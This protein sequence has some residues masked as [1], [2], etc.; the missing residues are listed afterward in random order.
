MK[1]AYD[2]ENIWAFYLKEFE[3][4]LNKKY[5]KNI[6]MSSLELYLTI[7]SDR[8][9]KVY[10]ELHLYDYWIIQKDTNTIL[11]AMLNNQE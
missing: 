2:I 8:S 3:F 9:M 6:S 5:T 10:L 11:F 7:E 1:Y 4:H